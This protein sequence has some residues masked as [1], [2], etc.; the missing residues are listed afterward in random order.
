MSMYYRL[1]RR[2]VI[3]GSGSQSMF[4]RARMLAIEVLRF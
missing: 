4:P 1:L 3:T 2:A